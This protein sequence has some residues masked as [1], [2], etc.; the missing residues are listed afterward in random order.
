MNKFKNL[1]NFVKYFQGKLKCNNN[2][3]NSKNNPAL[4]NVDSSKYVK[5]I[6]K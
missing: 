6:K 1:S 3:L 2:I 5:N 4:N